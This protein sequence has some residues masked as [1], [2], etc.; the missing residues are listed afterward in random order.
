MTT[1]PR[2]QF[3]RSP[4]LARLAYTWRGV[5]YGS[6]LWPIFAGAVFVFVSW[7]V[8]RRPRFRLPD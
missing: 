4:Y 2:H 7:W 1:K 3:A 8:E 6:L 5:F